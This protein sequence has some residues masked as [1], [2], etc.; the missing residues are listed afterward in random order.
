MHGDRRKRRY[1]WPAIYAR[2]IF[3]HTGAATFIIEDDMT[4]S[5]V[6]S[7]FTDLTGYRQEEVEG[8]LPWTVFIAEKDQER[9]RGYHHAR[10]RDPDSAPR[11][12]EVRVVD[13]HGRQKD[14]YMTA[15]MIPGTD[16]SVASMI[17]ISDRRRFEEDLRAAHEQMTAAFEEAKASQE[18]LAE[19]CCEME[20]YQAT[21]QG[22]I[23]FLP[24][25]T[26]V[27]DRTKTVTIWNRAMEELTGITKSRI[28]GRG[29]G[30]ILGKVSGVRSP[31]ACR[32]GSCQR[33]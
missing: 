26:F 6:N 4:V 28:I 17:D 19:Q 9:L 33:R 21:L 23:D 8:R 5:L 20:D 1:S 27:L 24:D 12:Y 29:P 25:P 7:G 32:E 30:A 14:V 16:R 2:S 22:I 10:R 31:A 18:T 11:T 13:R 15:G 3:E